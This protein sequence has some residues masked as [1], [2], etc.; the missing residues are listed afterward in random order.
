MKWCLLIILVVFAKSFILAKNDHDSEVYV[1]ALKKV[2]D[3]MINDVTSPVAAARYYAY[4]TM[5]SY[6]AISISHSDIYPSLGKIDPLLTNAVKYRPLE[7][8]HLQSSIL[9]LWKT[10]AS[11]LPSGIELKPLI[12]SLSKTL[13]DPSV[14]W[15]N[16]VVQKVVTLAMNDGFLQLNNLMRY[17]PKRGA[18]FWQPT[19]PAFM[20][21][22]EPHWN[23]ISP[24]VL[25]SASQFKPLPPVPFS[26]EK[27]A[28]FYSL[29]KEVYDVVRSNDVEKIAIAN[30]WDCNPYHISQIGHVE[31][32]TKKISPGGHW[33][34][35]TGIACI[36]KRKSIQET[37]LIHALVAITLHDAF[38]ACWD[39]KYRSHRV[40]PETAIR[41]FVDKSWK[42]ILQTPPFPEYLSGHSVASSA[43]AV[44]L[45]RIF[46]D[47]FT[48]EDNVE[49]EFG[50]PVRSFTSF[51][52]AAM[53]A[54]VSR[55]YG[56]IHFRDAIEQGI[57][58]G[59]QIGQFV[60]IQFK[61]HFNLIKK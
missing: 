26:V 1:A 6:E 52:E 15:I 37:S 45:S 28:P 53:E 60:A 41:E 54:S 11:L 22:I 16:Q 61:N 49:L 23:T 12:D 35:I 43:A 20:A 7:K 3:V 46:G 17:T 48:F 50:L 19:A 29:L 47:N 9:A 30:F 14:Q 5:A 33:I 58:Q 4:T 44:V 2:T 10:A 25:D 8:Q 51:S 31:F 24:L 42:P 36:K 32:G 55:L 59:K 21:P 40:R 27:N 13:P 39:E 38:I 56:G 18:A 34:G 57:W